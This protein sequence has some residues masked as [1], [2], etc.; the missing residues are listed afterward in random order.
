VVVILRYLLHGSRER[1][2]VMPGVLTRETAGWCCKL[3]SRLGKSD[4]GDIFL[5]IAHSLWRSWVGGSVG[6]GWDRGVG[7]EERD[8]GC[9]VGPEYCT[10]PPRCKKIT[11]SH[12]CFLGAH[13]WCL[14]PH[15]RSIKRSGSMSRTSWASPHKARLPLYCKQPQGRAVELQ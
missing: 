4:G 13:C 3:N 8:A 14:P 9:V 12:P 7:G 11:P 6:R 1:S 5:R 2:V 15:R 10:P